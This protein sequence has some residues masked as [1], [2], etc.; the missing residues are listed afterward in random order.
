M[1]YN[2]GKRRR[3]EKVAVD[4]ITGKHTYQ[5]LSTIH[6]V[7]VRSIHR[8]VS[9][10]ARSNT[11]VTEP[12]PLSRRESPKDLS[13]DV[14]QLQEELHNARTHIRLLEELLKIGKEQYGIDLRKK[15]GAKQS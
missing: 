7:S 5:E 11:I 3:K 6:G 1:K 9:E 10:Y 4:Y 12:P 8:W 13:G 2:K 15:N 14:K